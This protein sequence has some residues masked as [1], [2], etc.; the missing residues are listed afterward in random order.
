MSLKFKR[1]M[2]LLKLLEKNKNRKLCSSILDAVDD[3]AITCICEIV[4]NVIHGI[5]PLSPDNKKKLSKQKSTLRRL[6]LRGTSLKSKRKLMKGGFLP[7]LTSLLI[8]AVMP[9]LKK[10]LPF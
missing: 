10:I 9:L 2:R 3:G 5:V 6:A 8:P 4:K 7:L 1:H